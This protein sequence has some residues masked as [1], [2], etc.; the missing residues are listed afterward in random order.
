MIWLIRQVAK[1]F[2]HWDRP[3]Q[4]ALVMSLVLLIP[5]LG[6]AIG[7]P[8]ETRPI[9][10]FGAGALLI[11]AQIAVM[12]GG[13]G[14]VSAFTSAQQAYL[15]GDLDKTAA[16]LE[17][18]RERGRADMRAL[19]LLGNTYRQM[20]RLED[21]LSRLYEA[22]DKAPDHPF[23]LIGIGR[24]LLSGGQY[25]SAA[26]AFDRALAANA[27]QRETVCFD[28][29]HA[30]YRGGRV[31]EARAVLN[32]SAPPEDASEA[33]MYA[34]L[35]WRLGIGE[36]PSNALI[37]SGIVFWQNAAARF[38]DNDYGAALAGDLEMLSRWMEEER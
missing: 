16:L 23:P 2:P 9:A 30:L 15:A 17:S 4:I 13:R 35:R 25:D 7:A 33:L 38:A 22:L 32:E 19:T 3:T 6:I 11:M 14:M 8:E 26:E 10:W 18:L 34:Y 28:L 27:P 31:E 12:W 36:R 20:G 5:T 1:D 21:S 24:T 29:A 37:E